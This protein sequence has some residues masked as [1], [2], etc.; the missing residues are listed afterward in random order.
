[1]NWIFLKDKKPEK[2]GLYLVFGKIHFTP[3]HV[4][5]RDWYYGINL[6]HYHKK[7]EWGMSNADVITW[8]PLPEI[9]EPYK[10][11]VEEDE[12]RWNEEEKQ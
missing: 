6:C 7:F 1:M 4:D 3:D 2:D 12:K 11:I 5:D 10:S 9:P 8:M